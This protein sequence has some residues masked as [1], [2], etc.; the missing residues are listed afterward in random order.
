MRRILYALVCAIA[1][2]GIAFDYQTA[3]QENSQILR[4]I[5]NA[6]DQEAQEGYFAISGIKKTMFIF[7]PGSEAH[8]YFRNRVGRSVRITIEEEPFTA[9]R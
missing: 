4:G 6:T 8:T 5:V 3:A 2:S 9:T 1:I 7:E